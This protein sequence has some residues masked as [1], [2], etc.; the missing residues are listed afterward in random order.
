LNS[1]PLEEQYGAL[2]HSAISPAPT[3]LLKEAKMNHLKVFL[4]GQWDNLV[5]RLF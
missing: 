2:N 5:S 3:C 1:Q 4:W